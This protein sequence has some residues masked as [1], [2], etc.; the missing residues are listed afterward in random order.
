MPNYQVGNTIAI[1]T[2]ELRRKRLNDYARIYMIGGI[3]LGI[4]CM[5]HFAY[6][7]NLTNHVC[8]ITSEYDGL[9]TDICIFYNG[10]VVNTTTQRIENIMVVKQHTG[11]IRFNQSFACSI[12]ALLPYF[13]TNRNYCSEHN[14]FIVRDI[15]SQNHNQKGEN[16]ISSAVNVIINWLFPNAT[17]TISHVIK[18]KVNPDL[19]ASDYINTAYI[20]HICETS[21]VNNGFYVSMYFIIYFSYLAV[22]MKHLHDEMVMVNN[23]PIDKRLPNDATCIITYEPIVPNQIYYKCSQCVAVYDYAAIRHNWLY[24]SKNC[25]YCSMQIRKLIKY[26]NV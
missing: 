18:C 14:E 22:Y 21:K 26:R 11:E 2:S 6:Y 5:V 9:A 4:M 15:N 19:L 23:I 8:N 13:A 17:N 24:Y 3:V 20:Q 1:T 25:S 16:D 7:N 10:S 12:N